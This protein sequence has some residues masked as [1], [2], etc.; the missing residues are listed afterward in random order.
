MGCSLHMAVWLN[1]VVYVGGG[2]NTASY[3]INFYDP[4]NNLWCSPINTPYNSFAMTTLNNKLLIAG[5]LDK[6][7]K[8]TNQ[9]FI[10]DADQLKYYTKM[11]IARLFLVAAGHERML[12][13]TGGQDDEHKRVSST[14]L[15]DSSNG[16]WY[17]CRTYHSHTS[18]CDQ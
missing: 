10:M 6:H 4:V 15:F 2:F 3:I 18:T 1:I 8:M 12:I 9:I 7:Y 13:I 11:I 14:E 5:G 17:W 16:Q